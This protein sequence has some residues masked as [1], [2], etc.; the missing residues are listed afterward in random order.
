V[1]L[2]NK[3][4]GMPHVY[5]FNLDNRTDR[6]E[7]MESQ[8]EKWGIEYTRVSAS[9][10]LASEVDKWK[11][12]VDDE[13]Y[14]WGKY[15]EGT[16]NMINHMEMIKTWLKETNDP[17]MIMMEDDYD[18]NLIEYWHFDW[19]YL[20]NNI[21]HDWDCIQLGFE[22]ENVIHFFLHPKIMG[23]TY[24][25]PCMI[26]RRYAQ[27]LIDL[28]CIGDKYNFKQKINNHQFMF[29]TST[30]G[31]DFSICEAGKT[32]C[33]PLITANTDFGSYEDNIKIERPSHVRSRN[34]YYEFWTK[35]RDKFTLEDFFTYYKPYDYMM[36]AY[37]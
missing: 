16:G 2:N 14:G 23:G 11:H 27:K 3:L 26:N 24:F 31:V 37:E 15:P 13:I 36:T 33:I 29:E 21:P 18:L 5:Y 12:L 4:K 25:G 7:Y 34:L 10:Y 1:D 28:Y 30:V 35:H 6:R 20:M 19:E 17:Y 32:Y 9:K 22:S 8:F